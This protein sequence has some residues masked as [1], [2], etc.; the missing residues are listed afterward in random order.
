[1]QGAVSCIS[2]LMESLQLA[3]TNLELIK[4]TKSVPNANF[5]SSVGASSQAAEEKIVQH[6]DD[7]RQLDNSGLREVL[8]LSCLCFIIYVN[9]LYPYYYCRVFSHSR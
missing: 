3:K 5:Q 2:D 9:S 6:I 7:E 4:Q 8:N 1:M